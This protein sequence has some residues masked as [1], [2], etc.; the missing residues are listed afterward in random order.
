MLFFEVGNL[1]AERRLGDVQS[2]RSPR[3]VALFGKTMTACRWRTSRL[4][5][6]AQNFRRLTLR[7]SSHEGVHILS[8]FRT[9]VIVFCLVPGFGTELGRGLKLKVLVSGYRQPNCAARKRAAP[10]ASSVLRAG[11]PST[12][13][14]V[15]RRWHTAARC[16]LGVSSDFG[17]PT[18]RELPHSWAKRVCRYRLPRL[19]RQSQIL[20]S[21]LLL[22]LSADQDKTEP[23]TIPRKAGGPPLPINF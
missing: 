11:D 9:G 16:L 13:P 5:N 14:A 19:P 4:G 1:F 2:V 3:E 7:A 21:G 23:A 17:L 6:M 8:D 18:I 20:H 10:R 12:T 22:S 15:P